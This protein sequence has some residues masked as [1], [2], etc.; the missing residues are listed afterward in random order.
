M[1][2]KFYLFLF[3]YIFICRV[4][5]DFFLSSLEFFLVVFFSCFFLVTFFLFRWNGAKNN[6]FLNN[7]FVDSHFITAP[8]AAGGWSADRAHVGMGSE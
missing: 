6:K 1:M 2:C 8:T 5:S 7:L 4:H 3:L